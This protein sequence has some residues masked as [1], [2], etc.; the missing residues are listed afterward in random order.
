MFRT[1][2]SQARLR[3][4]A[5]RGAQCCCSF[6]ANLLQYLCAKNRQKTMLFDKV[7]EKRKRCNL[8]NTLF[9]QKSAQ[10][11]SIF[12]FISVI[13]LISKSVCCTAPLYGHVTAP[14]KLS[15]Y[16]YYYCHAT[17]RI[18]LAI[19]AGVSYC[20]DVTLG[21]CMAFLFM[22][23]HLQYPLVLVL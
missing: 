14:Y 7:N 3:T 23:S 5:R 4:V 18:Q 9:F 15:Y 11:S 13:Y 12:S 22:S 10:D 2:V 16:Y 17:W 1:F 21:P 6:V 8:F 20:L 19:H